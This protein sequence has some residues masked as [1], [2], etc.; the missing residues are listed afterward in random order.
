MWVTQWGQSLWSLGV[1]LDLVNQSPRT[2]FANVANGSI[3][4]PTLLSCFLTWFQD[5]YLYIDS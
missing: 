5:H 4:V 1:S 3:S 2:G